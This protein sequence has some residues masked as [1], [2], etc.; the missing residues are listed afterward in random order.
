MRSRKE[1]YVLTENQVAPPP[2][3][4]ADKKALLEDTLHRRIITMKIAPGSVIDEAELAEE[5]G[6]SKPPVRELL[7]K[8]AGEGYIELEP[9]RPPRV[10][11]MNYESLREYYLVSPMIYIATTKL[12]A[13]K[14]SAE[15]VSTLRAIQEDFRRAAQ[16]ENVED[17][18]FANNAF[19][20]QIGRIARN[21]YLMPSLRRILIDH[22]R[23]GRT[24]FRRDPSAQQQLVKAV[25]HHDLIIDAIEKHDPEEAAAIVKAHFDLS[26]KSMTAYVVPDNM[27]V[28]MDW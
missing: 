11:S 8:M 15:D 21:E 3:T 13:E 27:E 2:E 19:H 24:F 28:P 5:F 4:G 20:L 12:A 9:N 7:R 18:I 22:G 25:H 1:H 16:Q 23:V 10:T 14:A 26:R 17:R 6:L